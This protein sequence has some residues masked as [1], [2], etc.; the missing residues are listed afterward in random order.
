MNVRNYSIP[1][2]IALLTLS[3]ALVFA[4]RTPSEH[5]IGH[6]FGT[7]CDVSYRDRPLRMQ[8]HRAPGMQQQQQINPAQQR[9]ITTITNHIT[10]KK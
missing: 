4:C 7:Q 2:V 6:N 3:Q 9:R 5:V 8:T 10:G 1:G